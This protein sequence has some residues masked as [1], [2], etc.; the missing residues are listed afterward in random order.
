MPFRVDAVPQQEGVGD[1]VEVGM[2]QGEQA[3]RRR[4]RQDAFGGFEERNGAQAYREAV[5][6]FTHL[7]QWS[8]LSSPNHHS[9]KQKVARR[10]QKQAQGQFM[11]DL[12]VPKH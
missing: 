6:R 10:T 1:R 12:G 7:F 2:P 3:A 11:K 4:E 8:R 9:R 5:C